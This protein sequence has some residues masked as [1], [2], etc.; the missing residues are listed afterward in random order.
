ML[1]SDMSLGVL[2]ARL[3]HR[4][5][6]ML[7]WCMDEFGGKTCFILTVEFDATF[8]FSSD[9]KKKKMF[10]ILLQSSMLYCS[11]LSNPLIASH[12]EAKF[13]HNKYTW[14]QKCFV[15][16]LFKSV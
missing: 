3:I 15:V 5:V 2:T 10:F 7:V 13:K 4:G 14:F 6:V 8:G 11:A 9:L 1:I 12:M 16:F